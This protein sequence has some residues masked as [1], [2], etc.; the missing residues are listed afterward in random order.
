MNTRLVRILK[1]IV[2][3]LSLVPF[4]VL[5]QRFRTDQ[6]GSDPVQS[7]THFTG[8]WAVWFLLISLAITPV[9]RLHTSLAPLVRF[10]RMLGLFA[11]FYATLHL[12]T[13]IFLF[14]GFD[15]AGAV[16]S[17]RAHDF[18]AVKQ[19]WLAVWP[20]MV[21]DVKKRRFI[22]VGLFAYVI[23]LLLTITSPQR[24]LRAMG[25]KRW[26]M[27]H[28]TVYLAGVLAIVHF[29]WLVK[30]GNTQPVADTVVLFALLL[31]RPLSAWWDKRRRSKTALV[32]RPA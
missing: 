29:W 4:A 25:G 20:T 10:R 6:L 24:V 27:L 1:P 3:L 8:D 21:D 22:Q 32:S 31:A 15:L 13:Y 18:A 12:A 30:K 26:Q 2:F 11:F 5:V 16:A 28:R 14:S 23:L 17:V 9:R 7:I 19:Q